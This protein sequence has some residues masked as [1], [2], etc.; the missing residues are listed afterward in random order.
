MRPT[1]LLINGKAGPGFSIRLNPRSQN[2]R[3]AAQSRAFGIRGNRRSGTDSPLA[4]LRETKPPAR[5]LP[6]VP[7]GRLNFSLASAMSEPE[8][9]QP[10][11]SIAFIRTFL[12]RDDYF[13]PSFSGES[14]T[15][16]TDFS[17]SFVKKNFPSVG[18]IMICTRSERRC[19]TVY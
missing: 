9:D 14:A 8:K 17:T 7:P 3:L 16:E 13:A 10:G 6:A 5:D 2:R 11:I 1:H 19:A 12:L 18:T 15:A 4:A